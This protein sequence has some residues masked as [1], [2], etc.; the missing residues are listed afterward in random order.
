MREPKPLKQSLKEIADE[1]RLIVVVKL[2]DLVLWVAPDNR[3]GHAWVEGIHYIVKWQLQE[4]G[5]VK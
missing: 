4:R 3:E 2:A 1:I 5:L